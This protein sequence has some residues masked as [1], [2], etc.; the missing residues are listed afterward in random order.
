[1]EVYSEDD[2][3]ELGTYKHWKHYIG[4]V[5]FRILKD[6]TLTVSY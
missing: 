5:H 3:C 2:K 1:M 4:L 6:E